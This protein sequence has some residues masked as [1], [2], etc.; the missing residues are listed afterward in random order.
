M[1]RQANFRI[2]A[3]LGQRNRLAINQLIGMFLRDLYSQESSPR[4]GSAQVPR[5]RQ[6][7]RCPDRRT[8]TLSRCTARGT[9]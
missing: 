4:P 5:W 8:S 9:D 7:G 2:V 6:E 3:L 1:P